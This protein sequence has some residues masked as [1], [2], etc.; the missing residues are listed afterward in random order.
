MVHLKVCTYGGGT[1]IKLCNYPVNDGTEVR[2][3]AADIVYNR[4]G[5]LVY[6]QY[7]KGIALDPFY[8]E[9]EALLH[10]IQYALEGTGQG[11]FYIFTDCKI[12]V[13]AIQEWDISDIPSWRAAEMV[14]ICI[15]L[16]SKNLDKILLQHIDNKRGSQNR[17]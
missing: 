9:T 16:Y 15:N 6:V 17:A 7:G 13:N 3:K 10:A 12:L 11:K 8:A 4:R 1:A 14:M 2:S 5:D